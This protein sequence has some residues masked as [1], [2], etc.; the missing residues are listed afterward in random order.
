VTRDLDDDEQRW[1]AAN[2]RD[3][4]DVTQAL[5]AIQTW[6]PPQLIIGDAPICPPGRSPVPDQ[7]AS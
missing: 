5:A 4:Y 1:C 2:P 6:Q 7:A 3:S